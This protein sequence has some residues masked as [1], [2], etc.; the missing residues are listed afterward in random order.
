[1][2]RGDTEEDRVYMGRMELLGRM[3]EACRSVRYVP[4]YRP[5]G[6]VPQKCS[7]LGSYEQMGPADLQQSRQFWEGF[8]A[9]ACPS[10]V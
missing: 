9:V 1:M 10:V 6:D 4:A 5:T 3:K 2:P 7:L 8:P